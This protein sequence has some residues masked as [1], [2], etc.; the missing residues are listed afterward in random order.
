MKKI[1]SELIV[2]EGK[3]DIDFLSSFIQ[4]DFYQ[5]HGSAI[6]ENDIYFLKIANK[7]RGIIVLTDPDYPG[8]KIRSKIIKFIPDSKQA[9]IRK[10]V[11]I[12]HKKVGV[13]E[14][15]KKEALKALSKCTS[16]K[17]K[18]NN[19]IKIIDLYD[20]GLVGSINSFSKRLFLCNKLNIGFSNGKELLVKLNSIDITLEQI[21][22]EIKNVNTKRD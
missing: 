14:S 16:Y 5:V 18:S 22:K 7:K 1:I 2:V 10:E 15:T 19:K 20:L 17:S 11:S 4:A 8:I 21:K 13:A 6:N 9:Y 3:S 12:K